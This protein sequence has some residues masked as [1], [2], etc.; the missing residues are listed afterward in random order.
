MQVAL[1]PAELAAFR[2][3]PAEFPASAHV[4]EAG[5]LVANGTDQLRVL[6]VDG[7]PV[8]WAAPGA[9]DVVQ[10]LHRGRY[11]VQWRTF[12]GESFEPPSTQTVPGG[13]QIGGVDAGR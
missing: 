12:L 5:L 2:T 13:V 8:A 11:V 3:G 1:A 6:H 9:R 4:V 10:G 7:I